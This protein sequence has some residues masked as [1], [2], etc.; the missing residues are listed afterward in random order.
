VRRWSALVGVLVVALAG[1]GPLGAGAL[2]ALVLAAG[3]LAGAGAL[4]ARSAACW[5][6]RGCLGLA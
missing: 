2:V 3:V 4:R 6:A 5:Q 1:A